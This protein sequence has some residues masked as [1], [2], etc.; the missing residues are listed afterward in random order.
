MNNFSILW[1]NC[2][3]GGHENKIFGVENEIVDEG[4]QER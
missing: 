1:S 2:V 3:V 4:G